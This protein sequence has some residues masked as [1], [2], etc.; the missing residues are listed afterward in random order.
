MSWSD[1]GSVFGRC[2]QPRVPGAQQIAVNQVGADVL[3]EQ[4]DLGVGR[5][6]A[7]GCQLQAVVNDDLR[8]LHAWALQVQVQ[9]LGVQPGNAG[10]DEENADVLF[11]P[12]QVQRVGHQLDVFPVAQGAQR[13]GHVLA[14]VQDAYQGCAVGGLGLGKALCLEVVV[15]RRGQ[16][17]AVPALR[18][19]GFED[20]FLHHAL[21]GAHRQPQHFGGLAGAD[22]WA[23]TLEDF[24]VVVIPVSLMVWKALVW[25]F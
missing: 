24:H 13:L 20:A 1:R 25:T 11:D 16:N 21:H 4:L 22:V 12:H 23:G 7:V 9:G 2:R 15:Q 17:P 18:D 14:V 6:G 19:E 10:I 8:V 5:Q 3:F